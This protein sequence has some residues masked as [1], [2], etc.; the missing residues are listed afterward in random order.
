MDRAEGPKG[1]SMSSKSLRFFRDQSGVTA[2]EY[3]LI[4]GLISLGIITG[5]NEIGA[6]W[7][8][9]VF[10]IIGSVK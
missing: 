3:G 5:I 4:A 6:G 10:A 1:N 2:I 9:V 8:N 7:A